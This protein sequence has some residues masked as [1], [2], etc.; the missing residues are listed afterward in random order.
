MPNTSPVVDTA[1]V[2]GALLDRAEQDAVVRVGF[3][4]AITVGQKGDELTEQA[5]LAAL[6]AV[7][8]QR[9]RPPGGRRAR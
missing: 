3:F 1:A 6:G 2:L 5:E 8:L 7:G 9:R 4:A